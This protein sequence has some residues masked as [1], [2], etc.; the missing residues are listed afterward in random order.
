MFEDEV[1]K[2]IPGY[3]ALYQAS[4]LG[5][6]KSYKKGGELI[7][8]PRIDKDGYYKVILAD[9]YGI[10]KEYRLHRL[11]AQTFLENPENLPVVNHKDEDITNNKVSN[12]EW[13]SV[14]YNNNYGNRNKK[15]SQSKINS[16]K[17]SKL[18]KEIKPDGTEVIYP[19]L[20]EAERQTGHFT[21]NISSAIKRNG[22]CGKSRWEYL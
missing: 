2:W 7:L 16:P 5:N 17:T 10:R 13:C 20:K 15:I 11:I 18:V 21:G 9:C 12:L 1:W 14:K 22:T 19:S 3:E 4:N 8:K 6:I